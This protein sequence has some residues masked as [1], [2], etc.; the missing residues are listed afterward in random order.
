MSA[1]AETLQSLWK[2]LALGVLTVAAI[3]ILWKALPVTLWVRGLLDGVS[4]LGIWGPLAYGFIYVAAS[5]LGVPRTP[6]NVGAGIVFSLPV[7]LGV[8]LVC[9]T[10]T[11]VL[12][13]E[14]A[15]HVASDWVARKIDKVPNARRIM[16]AVE[17]EGFKLVLLLRMNPFLPAVIKGYGFGTTSLKMRT[18]LPASI[19]GFLPIGVAHVFLGWLGGTAMMVS[20]SQPPAWRYGLLIGGGLVSL[21]LIVFVTWFANRALNKRTG[22]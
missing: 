13:F 2:P 9:A 17:R 21:L 15:R 3:A 5:L 12:T 7:A 16:D 19:L 14:I 22:D 8:V 20:S 18:Y 1:R 4:Q 11:F 6:L 10:I